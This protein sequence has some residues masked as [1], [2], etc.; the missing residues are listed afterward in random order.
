ME[1][2]R[3]HLSEAG[4]VPPEVGRVAPE[5]KPPVV[6]YQR[7]DVRH[8]TTVVAHLLSGVTCPVQRQDTSDSEQ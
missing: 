7:L 6:A 2:E 5:P 3:G 4:R 8:E 1:L